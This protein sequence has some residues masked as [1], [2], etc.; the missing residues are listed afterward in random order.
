[1]EARAEPRRGN[2]LFVRM[3]GLLRGQKAPVEPEEV[4][5]APRRAPPP[6]LEEP[7]MAPRAE[8]RAEARAEPRVEERPEP[9]QEPRPQVR[10]LPAGNEDMF[11][12]PSFLRRQNS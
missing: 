8:V 4:S 3:T 11:E 5:R 2:S 6:Q 12:I 10:P 9:R 7:R 1:V